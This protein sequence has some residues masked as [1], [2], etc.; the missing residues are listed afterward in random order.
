MRA[1][2]EPL[3][4]RP[5]EPG[6]LSDQVE[7]QIEDLIVSGEFAVGTRLPGER[8][9]LQRFSVSRTVIRE[10]ISRLESRGLLRVYPSS[11][12]Y[13][14]GTPEWGVRAQWQ[15]WVAG[16]SDKLLAILEVRECL[17]TRAAALATERATDEDLAELRLAQLNFEQQVERRSVADMSHWDKVFHLQ[18]ATCSRNSVLASFVQ[19]V[20]DVITAQRRSILADQAV[21]RRSLVQHGRIVEA[22]EAQDA[23]RAIRAVAEHLRST[24]ETIAALAEDAERLPVDAR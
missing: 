21:A 3:A 4:V 22:I 10:A 14:T 19:N 15:S 20:N 24:R 2:P 18:L 7:A 23:Q 1:R 6:R 12:T 9:L 11:G 5:P 16:D 13:V 8:A 17:E